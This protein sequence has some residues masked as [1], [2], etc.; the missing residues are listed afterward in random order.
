MQDELRRS[1]DPLAALTQPHRMHN[2][3]V[4][5]IDLDVP[6]AWA[7]HDLDRLIVNYEPRAQCRA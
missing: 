3:Y 5:W 6:T 2:F 7:R 4:D 1:S